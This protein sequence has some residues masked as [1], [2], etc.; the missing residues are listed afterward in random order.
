M[1]KENKNLNKTLDKTF[2]SS[3]D[4]VSN[5]GTGK[6][7]YG[8]GNGSNNPIV[9]NTIVQAKVNEGTLFEANTRINYNKKITNAIWR[10]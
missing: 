3:L 2:G 8:S 9:I 7:N 4:Y 10:C 6:Y 5:M 1:K